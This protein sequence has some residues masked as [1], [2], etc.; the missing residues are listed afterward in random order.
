VYRTI[1]NS[2][3]DELRA[4]QSQLFPV[5]YNDAFYRDLFV[6]PYLCIVLFDD[7]AAADDDDDA[8]A[9]DDGGGG[10]GSG[11]RDGGDENT[12][13]NRAIAR[14][15]DDEGADVGSAGG[16]NDDASRPTDN[17]V[18]DKVDV[19]ATRKRLAALN[20]DNDGDGDKSSKK[21]ETKTKANDSRRRR[22]VGV[23]TSRVVVEPGIFSDSHSA[24]IAT[25]GVAPAYQRR[26]VASRLLQLMLARIAAFSEAHT[27]IPSVTL[28]VKADNFAA[29]SLYT[30][31]GFLLLGRLQNHY[32]WDETYFDALALK[33]D[34]PR[35][36]RSCAIM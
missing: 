31:A 12:V 20:T 8:E 10:C 28:H 11:D 14:R 18:G 25:L 1:H 13:T 32:Y 24:Y 27:R 3:L 26:G 21:R 29:I 35:T 23:V 34:L 9:D 6:D 16:G 17:D 22:L 19:E 5:R 33:M 2:D 30:R 7:D 15:V 4:L 36:R